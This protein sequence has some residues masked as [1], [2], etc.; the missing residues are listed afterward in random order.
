M[1]V[2]CSCVKLRY[3][4]L[5]VKATLGTLIVLPLVVETLKP[6]CEE[7]TTPFCRVWIFQWRSCPTISA[8]TA[9]LK[10]GVCGI[11]PL[12]VKFEMADRLAVDYEL[13]GFEPIIQLFKLVECVDVIRVPVMELTVE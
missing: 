1:D 11:V 12:C 8:T 10:I 4:S 3:V 7:V 9:S 5:D 2:A 13:V 6:P